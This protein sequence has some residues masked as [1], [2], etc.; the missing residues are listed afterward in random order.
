MKAPVK[1]IV[2]C[3]SGYTSRE[4]H[5]YFVIAAA[6][7]KAYVAA[8]FE[9]SVCQ[10]SLYVVDVVDFTVNVFLTAFRQKVSYRNFKPLCKKNHS[11]QGRHGGTVFNATQHITGDEISGKL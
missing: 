11:G 2:L 1:K 3:E 6:E 10:S 4:N 7:R 5:P 8:Y 9:I